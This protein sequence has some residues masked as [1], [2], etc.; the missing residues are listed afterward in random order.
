MDLHSGAAFWPLKNGLLHSYP[1]IDRDEQGD[2]MVI[3]AGVTGALTALHLARAG[4]NVV[5]LDK[6]DVATGSTAATTG[7][8]LYETDTDLGE[9][10]ES[11]GEAA[12][13]RAWRAG[14]EAIDH[15]EALCSSL[16][17]CGFERRNTL[18]LASSAADA[19]GLRDEYELRSRHGFD[20]EWLTPEALDTRYGI[21]RHGAIGTRGSAQID[22]YRF[23]H[24]LLQAAIAHGARVYDRSD[25]ARVE[26][27]A[28]GVRGVTERGPVVSA[29][30]VVWATGYEA[31][32]ETQAAHGQRHS[33]WAF[34]SEPL[35]DFG[36]WRDRAL[37]WETSRPYLY[38]RSTDDGRA[39]VGGEDEPWAEG[40][41]NPALMEEKTTHLQARFHELFPDLEIEVAY[42]WAGTFTNTADGLPYI[43]TLPAHPHAWLAL[44]YGGNGITFSMIAATLI[45]DA[46][47]GVANP[48]APL[49]SFDRSTLQ[50]DNR[51]PNARPA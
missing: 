13:V 25:V 31:L 46:W 23:T 16:G 39:M 27:D 24:T 34:V 6:R 37:I 30:H 14:I 17:S 36:S 3:G 48:D 9:L 19:R 8:L 50:G 11:I 33:T 41:T 28:G 12:A 4:A 29:G 38:A 2:V 22:S 43:G 45:R 18:Y 1:A 49:F 5:V 32:E 7:L 26:A 51:W 44:G 42:R 35:A 40:H 15:I 10:R 21:R 20:V 47:L